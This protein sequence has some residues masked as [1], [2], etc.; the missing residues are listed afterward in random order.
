MNSKIL[1]LQ[2]EDRSDNFLNKLLYENKQICKENEMEYIFINNGSDKI[3]PYWRKVFEINNIIN[4]D[5][6]KNLDY[7]MWLDSDAFLF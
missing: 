6:N 2:I 5:K 1:V 7:I 4:D 3:P